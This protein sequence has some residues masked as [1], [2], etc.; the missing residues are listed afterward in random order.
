MRHEISVWIDGVPYYN[1]VKLAFQPTENMVQL[2]NMHGS[3]RENEMS[4]N[5]FF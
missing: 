1:G 5:G 2:P 4:G 3:W